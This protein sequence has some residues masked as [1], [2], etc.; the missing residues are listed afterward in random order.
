MAA[1]RNLWL[2]FYLMA[3]TGEPL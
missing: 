3:V 2:A 1:A